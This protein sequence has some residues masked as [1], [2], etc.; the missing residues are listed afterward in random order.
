MLAALA[1]VI[2]VSARQDSPTTRFYYE[3]PSYIGPV[4]EQYN[5]SEHFTCTS[6]PPDCVEQAKVS[7]LRYTLTGGG[8]AARR[9][10][11]G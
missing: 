8:Q 4:A 7:A 9:S 1:A 11:V 10:C 3:H 2:G 6:Q 5:T